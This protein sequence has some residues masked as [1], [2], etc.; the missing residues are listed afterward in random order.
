MHWAQ[1]AECRDYPDEMFFSTA[2]EVAAKRVCLKCQVRKECRA[3]ALRPINVSA[4]IRDILKVN[5]D[6]G[7]DIV[8]VSGVIRGAVV[9]DEY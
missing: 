9:I 3:D 2:D 1:Q 4:L 7:E 6:E 5:L 8:P